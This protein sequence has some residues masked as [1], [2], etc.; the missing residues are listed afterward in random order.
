M[1]DTELAKT[2]DPKI[3]EADWY[4]R[5]EGGGNF[6]CDPSSEAEPYV[7]MM[8][9]P[10]V[11]GSLHMGHALTFTLQDL[12]IR[13][14][15]MRGRDTLWQPGQD[16]AGIA[17]QMVVERQLA[18][19]GIDRRDMGREKFLERM[20]EWKAESGG[21]IQ[22]QMRRLGAS[23]DW[24]RN[25]FT[26]DDG[27]SRAVIKIFVQMH[28]DGLI[29][30]DKRL[31]NWDPKLLTAISDLEV[32]QR[33]QES[34]MWHLKYRLEGS[35]DEYISIATTR[36]ETMLGDGAVAVHPDDER[37]RH[38]VGRM[39]ILPLSNRP[40]PIIADEYPD[41]EKGSGAVK[42]TPAHDFND[43]EV[44][45][46]HDLPLINLMT[47]QAKMEAIPEIPEKYQGMDRYEARKQILADLAEEGLV[48]REEKVLNSVPHG[49]RSGVVIEPWLMD[50][51]YVNAAELAKPAIAAVEDGRTRFV[52]ER[53]SKTYF[54]WMR[55]IQPWC[56]SRQ[57]W[58]GHRIPAWYGPDDHIFVEEDEAA[59]LAAAQAHYGEA[60]ELR[61]DEDVLDTWFSSGLWPFSTL[62]WPDGTDEVTRDLARYYPG[63]VLVT[64]FD[65]IFFWVARMMMM[66][67]YAMDGEVPFRDVYIHA[68][69]RDEKGQKMSKSKGNVMDPLDL[70]DQYGADPLRFTLTAMAAQGRDIKMST[71]RLESYR[72]FAT[73]IWNACRFLQMNGCTGGAG[74]ID[75][76][77]VEEPVN[78]WIVAEYNEAIAK[79]TAAIEAY[80][81]NEA[82]DAL[83]SFVW[84]SYCDW[85]VELIKPQLDG[86]A[87]ETRATAAA[88]LAG[89]LRLLHPIMPYLTEE[90][91]EKIFASS[92]MMIT[93]AWPDA[94][95]L[96]QTDSPK[97]IGFLINLISDIRYIRSEMNVP[98][99][100]K[101]VLQLRGA[102]DLQTRSVEVNRAALLRLARLEGIET[103]ENFGSGT[104]RGTVDGVD[105]GLPLA[106]ILDLDA[107]R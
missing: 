25:R 92:D 5:W 37:Y 71:T 76:A 29:Y 80:R 95:A 28:R 26:L 50:Q 20:W 67:M 15:R 12:L 63:A 3:I 102:S 31:V 24:E 70:I 33:E 16:H 77:K 83:Y 46:R 32:E 7:I 101:P 41:P 44:G 51:W 65:I 19:Q 42:I 27:L 84:H 94:V 82:A 13:F 68:L 52:P 22:R 1:S 30:R 43:F 4:E 55:N 18:E 56:I 106:G 86:D 107:E 69:V 72:N 87:T 59:A 88:I 97:E 103:V 98:L 90:L 54:D 99:S 23:P 48:E 104:A 105:I 47:A 53:W 35:E 10:N 11:T 14:N 91:N 100:A 6:A 96:P 58:W 9:P 49:D 40:I 38:M 78:R 74:E 61:R 39:C 60:V 2:Y 89:S 79:T 21:T 8:P 75:L 81:F 64:G 85:Y 45:R 36:P 66:S 34:S 73:K 57:L 93:E 17:T 62:G